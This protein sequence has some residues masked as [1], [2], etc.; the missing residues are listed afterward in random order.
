MSWAEISL[1]TAFAL[2]RVNL[3][4]FSLEEFLL[5]RSGNFSSSLFE[6]F[7]RIIG[8]ASASKVIYSFWSDFLNLTA[9]WGIWYEFCITAT[10]ATFFKPPSFILSVLA[11]VMFERCAANIPLIF[12]LS[13]IFDSD[14]LSLI[15][16]RSSGSIL[17]VL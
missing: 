15:F 13:D 7:L 12:V 2:Y 5:S 9:F 14:E 4:P 1:G 3:T 6:W 11:V 10:D 16:L 17:F 8:A